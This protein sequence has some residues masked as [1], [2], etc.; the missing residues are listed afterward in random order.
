MG[1]TSHKDKRRNGL[2]LEVAQQSSF[3]NFSKMDYCL[4]ICFRT[5]TFTEQKLNLSSVGGKNPAQTVNTD[6]ASSESSCRWSCLSSAYQET[7]AS[8]TQRYH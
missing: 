1:D 8:E 6:A 3:H 7:A 4:H 5:N 2:P